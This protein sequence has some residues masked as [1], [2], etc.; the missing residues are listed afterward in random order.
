MGRMEFNPDTGEM[1]EVPEE[2]K[3]ALSHKLK[4]GLPITPAPVPPARRVLPPSKPSLQ[5]SPAYMLT[6]EDRRRGGLNRNPTNTIPEWRRRE[7]AQIAAKKR[8]AKKT[9]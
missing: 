8:W 3:P 7:I 6:D 9:G 5:K 2:Y 4:Q 1:E